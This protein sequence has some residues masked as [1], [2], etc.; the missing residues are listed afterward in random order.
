MVM[1]DEEIDGDIENVVRAFAGLA[2]NWEN[3][4]RSCG[5]SLCLK[6]G[7]GIAVILDF[8][9]VTYTKKFM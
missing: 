5:S 6:N 4:S 8:I 3:S 2:C 1:V 9:E 7:L